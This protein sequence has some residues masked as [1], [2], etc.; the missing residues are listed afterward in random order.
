MLENEYSSKVI[1]DGDKN[2]NEEMGSLEKTAMVLEKLNKFIRF[3]DTVNDEEL[4]KFKKKLSIEQQNY[5]SGSSMS[6]V[7]L[8]EYIFWLKNGFFDDNNK[9]FRQEIINSL[10][11]IVKSEGINADFFGIHHMKEYIKLYQILEQNKLNK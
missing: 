11:Q 1:V 3:N 2:N 5:L 10:D 7:E 9:E 8:R 4:N 6:D